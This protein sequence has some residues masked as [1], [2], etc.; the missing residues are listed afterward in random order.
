MDS[1]GA[2][3]CTKETDENSI[4]TASVTIVTMLSKISNNI[5]ITMSKYS[6]L[7]HI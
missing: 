3:R 2:P 5:I 6:K 4:I 7:W 1:C